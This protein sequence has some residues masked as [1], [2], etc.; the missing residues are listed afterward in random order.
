MPLTPAEV[1]NVAFKKPPIGKRGYDEEEVDAFLD[2]VEVELS[3]LIEEN[4]DLRTR[5]S[6]G[7]T[8]A[9]APVDDS[10]QQA[11]A[12][13]LA[14]ARDENGRLRNQVAELER[15]LSG[16]QNDAQQQVVQLQQ[17]LAQLEQQLAETRSALDEARRS[18][19]TAATG[20]TAVTDHAQQAV[21]ILAMAQQTADQHLDQ[22]KAEADRLLAEARANA[23]TTVTEA[24]AHAEQTIAEA[25]ARAKRTVEEADAKASTTLTDAEQR[26]TRQLSEAE[27]RARQLDEESTS[28]AQR[29]VSEAE[30]RA[31]ALTADFEQ[32]KAGLEQRIEELRV[33]EREYRSR[34][35]DYLEG[36]LRELLGRDRAEPADEPAP[37]ASSVAVDLDKSSDTA[38]DGVQS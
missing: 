16:G 7:E 23:E 8:L 36:Q 18:T 20:G 3:R 38:T 17:Q 25:D 13:E 15:A 24:N 19:P 10:A 4:T 34:L 1:H 32:R 11:A 28:K 5:M 33:F 31:A 29:T 21:A 26:S 30:Q 12:A 27:T 37:A 14:T 9:P 22:S 2:I 6:N 35:K